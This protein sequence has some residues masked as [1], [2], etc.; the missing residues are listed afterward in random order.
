MQVILKLPQMSQERQSIDATCGIA[1]IRHFVI[2]IRPSI[3]NDNTKYSIL[4]ITI[5]RF[6]VK[7]GNTGSFC[8]SQGPPPVFQLTVCPWAHE[9]A[10]RKCGS[11]GWCYEGWCPHHPKL[12]I[13]TSQH[14]HHH[15][16][17][18][19]HHHNH[20]DHDIIMS[21][22]S[23]VHHSFHNP[24]TITHLSSLVEFCHK[25]WNILILPS[26]RIYISS[27]TSSSRSWLH[28]HYPILPQAASP[29][30]LRWHSPERRIS[31]QR[32]IQHRRCPGFVGWLVTDLFSSIFAEEFHK[33][34]LFLSL[35]R[36]FVV[37]WAPF[38][39]I[40]TEAKG[41][42]L[43]PRQKRGESLNKNRGN[44]PSSH[45]S[46]LAFRHLKA[47]WEQ[48][49]LLKTNNLHLQSKTVNMVHTL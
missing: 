24:W 48:M 31:F 9:E 14:Q 1:K 49:D 16:H 45:V 8:P 10:S 26:N 47:K 36:F 30:T 25:T 2:H 33:A 42:N 4:R 6:H 28:I 18:H 46:A 40:M 44:H 41:E 29:T 27:M 13:N 23:T 5:N 7:L 35:S 34:L 22:Q 43:L 37:F 21:W 20:C 11:V 32:P 15:H 12:H 17:H 38:G 3:E 19:H 39:K